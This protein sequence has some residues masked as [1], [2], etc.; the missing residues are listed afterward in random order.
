MNTERG[1]ARRGRAAKVS[2]VAAAALLAGG[3][4]AAGTVPAR[5]ATA[6]TA[7]AAPAAASQP[8]LR[9]GSRGAAVTDW[10]ATLNKLA[11]KGM[12][13]Q[14]KIAAD[15]IFG[16][17]TKA[18]TQAFQRWAHISADGIVGVQTRAV[19]ATALS[20]AALDPD[21]H[22]KPVLREGSRGAAVRDWQA[23]VNKLAAAGK[24]GQATIAADGIF[25]PKTK[26]ATQAF[27]RWAHISADGIVGVQ[28]YTAAA[29]AAG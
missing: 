20:S 25:G 5:A 15:G 10:Q 7:T 12:P 29:K 18:A 2:M 23:T 22:L 14:P 24:P 8:L 16:P 27:Q 4:A 17:K 28:T 1:A 19:A 13:S 26:A 21:P 6:G 11:A 3:L 9:E